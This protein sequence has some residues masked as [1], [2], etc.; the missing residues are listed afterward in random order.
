M[1][2]GSVTGTCAPPIC[3]TVNHGI[4]SGLAVIVI[5]EVA[6][7]VDHGCLAETVACCTV[8][9][10]L[11]IEH[12]GQSYPITGPP[13]SVREKEGSLRTA[14]AVIGMREVISTADETSIGST[15]VMVGEGRVDK[16]CSFC[17]LSPL[18]LVSDCKDRESGC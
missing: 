3:C 16:S 2:S 1:E 15:N 6:D 14:G 4:A 17:G 8:G 10:V 12:A 11:D 5:D 9:I 7:P 13:S 18:G